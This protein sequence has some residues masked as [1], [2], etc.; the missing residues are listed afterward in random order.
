MPVQISIFLVW[1]RVRN[2][3]C[4]GVN[5]LGSVSSGVTSLDMHF[6]GNLHIVIE[7]QK[8]KIPA[9]FRVTLTG[10]THSRDPFLV[11]HDLAKFASHPVSILFVE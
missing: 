6:S 7:E 2:K 10:K 11:G 5:S 8:H 1:G 4:L 3:Q 9:Y